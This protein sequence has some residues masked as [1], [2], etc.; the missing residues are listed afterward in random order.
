M[1]A[2]RR[3]TGKLARLS[4]A[5]RARAASV[6]RFLHARVAAP[7]TTRGCATVLGAAAVMAAVW[8]PAACAG[9]FIGFSQPGIPGTF[10]VLLFPSY[11]H[12]APNVNTGKMF[13]ELAYF[14]KTG[15]TGTTRDQFETWLGFY[16]G[17]QTTPKGS[18]D[19][20]FG[21]ST[22]EL[23]LEYYYHV[24][25]SA[26][27]T[28]G[29]D[30]FRSW[31]ISPMLIFNAPN[32]SSKTGG[33]GAGA[34]QWSIS[35]SV[36]NYFGYGRWHATVAPIA[37]AYLF[38]NYNLTELPSG[39]GVRMRGGLSLS[40]FDIAAGYQFIPNLL[41]GIHHVY[42]IY[43]IGG[44]DFQRA[45]EGMIGPTFTYLGFAAQ[46]CFISGTLDVDYHHQG[47]PRSVSVNFS[48]VKNF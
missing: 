46:N 13:T 6:A 29:T 8:S 10:G 1:A 36:N 33:F 31:W 22:P 17:V 24:V 41:A 37:G 40:L 21:I 28:F 14:S 44:S 34:N 5:C 9:N 42:N 11:S 15:V 32:G 26:D 19:S 45:T 16:S 3:Q 2:A 39:S 35:A 23:G 48:L 20:A 43:N 4:R 7:R 25:E 38:H 18:D 47:V 12:S 30:D 27:N